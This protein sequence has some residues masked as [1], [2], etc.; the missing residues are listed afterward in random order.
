M[1]LRRLRRRLRRGADRAATESLIDSLGRYSVPATA[2]SEETFRELSRSGV[3]VGGARLVAVVDVSDA[4]IEYALLTRIEGQGAAHSGRLRA[5]GA[6]LLLERENLGEDWS[7]EW[8]AALRAMP[9]RSEQELGP[10]RTF[11]WQASDATDS[12]AVEAARRLDRN[13]RVNRR[14]LGLLREGSSGQ[15]EIVPQG[16][17]MRVAVHQYGAALPNPTALEA[18]LSVAR[19]LTAGS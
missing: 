16:K 6:H 14:V 10:V 3:V 17:W 19:E 13:D 1:I 8:R 7:A 5:V 11:E 15:F 2:A 4:E 12:A 9:S 18:L